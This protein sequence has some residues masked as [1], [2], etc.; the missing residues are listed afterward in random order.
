MYFLCNEGKPV[1]VDSHHHSAH[2][3]VSSV[4]W[5]R[6]MQCHNLISR[7]PLHQLEAELR[8]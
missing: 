2:I 3:R 7:K 1:S 6:L 8:K 5:G 4:K